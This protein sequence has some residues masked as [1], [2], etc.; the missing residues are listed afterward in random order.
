MF[1]SK[2]EKQEKKN[3]HMHIFH[4]W[5]FNNFWSIYSWSQTQYLVRTGLKTHHRL[6]P[7]QWMIRYTVLSPPVIYSDM[8]SCIFSEL[9][10]QAALNCL[11]HAK[12]KKTSPLCKWA[13]TTTT[14]SEASGEPVIC[15]RISTSHRM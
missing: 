6:T 1:Q 2:P 4:L 15:Q 14:G 5:H 11:W 13:K 10:M 7:C 9:A 8:I 3:V 12:A